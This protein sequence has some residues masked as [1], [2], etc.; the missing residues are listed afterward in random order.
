MRRL[1]L[2][3]L[4]P[5]AT[6]SFVL[7]LTLPLMELERLFFLTDR[8]SLVEIVNGLWRDGEAGLAVLVGGLS[9]AF[10][11]AKILALHVAAVAGRSGLGLALMNALGRWSMMDV[12]LVA[13]V[14]FAAKTSGLA[15]AA[16]LPGLWCYGAAT[17]LTACGAWL[18]H[19]G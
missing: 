18:A 10:P 6:V 1:V 11:A 3:L 2:S 19:R 4:L 12:M 17:L 15:A 9:I 13:L 5:S 7:G 14:V 8:P 16:T